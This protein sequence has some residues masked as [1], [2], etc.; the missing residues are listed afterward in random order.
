MPRPVLSG[1][2][3]KILA[4][5]SMLID[6]VGLMFFPENAVFRIFGRLAFPI[7]AY[8]IAEGCKYTKNRLRYFLTV[9]GMGALCQIA[10][11]FFDGSAYMCV[12]ITFSLSIPVVWAL[13]ACKKSPG[14]QS[15]LVLAASVAVVFM[16]NR[17]FDIDYGFW[18]CMLPV[19]ASLF[20]GTKLDS[21]PVN[22]AAWSVGL[23]CLAAALGGLQYWS[24]LAVPVLLLYS[25]KRGKWRMKYF[26]YIFYP[27]H[28]A[29]L[30][31]LY[32]LLY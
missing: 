31:G 14:W 15:G 25:G 13:E 24:V 1:N 26:F 3:L 2:A 29:L 12:F 7:F 18:G 16:L 4:A 32:M 19:F 23:L 8:M 9:F 17:V 22:V 6:H 10:Y 30:E 5:I 21:T 20:H 27:A 28:L 11:Y